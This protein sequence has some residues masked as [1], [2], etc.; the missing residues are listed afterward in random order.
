V[1]TTIARTTTIWPQRILVADMMIKGQAS[2][3]P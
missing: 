1:T 3:A 2:L